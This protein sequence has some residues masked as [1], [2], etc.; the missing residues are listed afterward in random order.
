MYIYISIRIH[1]QHR[2]IH[3]YIYTHIYIYIYVCI[4]IHAHIHIRTHTQSKINDKC[5]ILE[6]SSSLISNCGAQFSEDW[7][8]WT[9]MAT[10]W[11]NT[12][13][14]NSK[15]RERLGVFQS[16]AVCWRFDPWC[17]PWWTLDMLWYAQIKVAVGSWLCVCLRIQV[18]KS[19]D[20]ALLGNSESVGKMKYKAPT[21]RSLRLPCPM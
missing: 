7:L 6:H 3:I 13:M 12:A 9:S 5:M 18:A 1:I 11:R 17:T 20:A 21:F 19:S 4:Y 8:S 2:D 14:Q 16:S 10:C 15:R